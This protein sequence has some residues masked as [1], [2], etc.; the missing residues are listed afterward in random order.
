MASNKKTI[1]GSSTVNDSGTFTT[2]TWVE[3]TAAGVN[4]Y[5]IQSAT[6]RASLTLRGSGD[7]IY[8]DDSASAF[9]IKASGKTI[10]LQSDTQK[11]TIA[12]SSV[13]KTNAV[14]ASLHFLDGVLSVG[15][16]AGGTAL[17]LDNT[18][19][20][21][22]AL[23]DINDSLIREDTVVDNPLGVTT[24]SYTG[25]VNTFTLTEVPPSIAKTFLW[26][27]VNTT[28]LKNLVS[29][30][31]TVAN[32]G[33][34]LVTTTTSN[35]T[36]H[37][38]I[39]GTFFDPAYVELLNN[40]IN[41]TTYKDLV[42]E[43][44]T[45]NPAYISTTGKTK[46]VLE[47]GNTGAGDDV[48]V[49][50]TAYALNGAYINGGGGKNTLEVEMK[51]PFAQP[52][53]LLNIQ[54]VK[55]HNAPNYYDND[56][57]GY[58]NSQRTGSG[59]LNSAGVDG[60][61]DT[62]NLQTPDLVN[63][64][65]S[66]L[67][68]TN[69]AKLENLVVT[70]SGLAG[71][72]GL[73]GSGSVPA[74]DLTILGIKNYP[75][76]TLEGGFSK[77]V[78][79][80]YTTGQKAVL[81]L[82]LVN[83]DFT[84]N[85]ATN[86][87]TA[88]GLLNVAHN[89]GHVRI[90]SQGYS[91]ILDQ[92][93]F[94][95]KFQKLTV[96]GEG[97][98]SVEEDLQFAWGVAT[99]DASQNTGGLLVDV[100]GDIAAKASILGL[101][102]INITGSQANDIISVKGAV[103]GALMKI[104]L[105][106]G[107]NNVLNLDSAVNAGAKSV[108]GST[109]GTLTV[110]VNVKDVDLTR[111]N[112]NDVDFFVLTDAAA[113]GA[114][115]DGVMGT[116]DDVVAGT[117]DGVNSANATILKITQ[118]QF[119]TLGADKFIPSHDG[120]LINLKV[121]ISADTNFADLGD[122]S[123]LDSNV[124]LQ[125]DIAQR[126]TLTM[127]AAQLD[128][129]VAVGGIVLGNG[130]TDSLGKLKITDAG[131]NFDIENN[132]LVA[133]PENPYNLGGTVVDNWGGLKNV[134]VIHTQNGYDRA[135]AEDLVDTLTIDSTA[136]A[137]TVNANA[138]GNASQFNIN[139]EKLIIQGKHDVGFTAPV[140]FG[141]DNFKI[142]ASA[143]KGVT[144]PAVP[145]TPAV[146]AADGVTVITPAVPGTP[147]STTSASLNGLTI[148]DFNRITIGAENTWGNVKGTDGNDRV[149]VTLS[150]N[151]GTGASFATGGLKSTGVE[152]YVV[153][154][155]DGN[156]TFNVCDT[157]QGL[158]TLGLQGNAGKV[159]TFNNVKFNVGFI[160]EGDGKGAYSELPK[161]AGNPNYSNVG[162]LTAKYYTYDENFTANVAISN[163]GK[164]LGLQTDGV[165]A[166]ILHVDG[167]NIDN[168]KIANINIT[169]GNAVIAGINATGAN[170]L[171]HVKLNSAND[172]TVSLNQEA[173]NFTNF[174][175]SA[176]TGTTT[177]VIG[178]TDAGFTPTYA[179]DAFAVVDL[180]AATVTGIEA[181]KIIEGGTLS[182][183]LNQLNTITPAKITV[184]D[185][186]DAG[187][188]V[189]NATLN[190]VGL[191][192]VE[193]K[194]SSF[195]TGV[196]LGTLTVAN[197]TTDSISNNETITLAATTDLTGVTKII[198][199]AGMTLNLTAAQ[200]QQLNGKGLVD[201]NGTINITNLKQTDVDA[202]FDLSGIHNIG[203]GKYGTITLAENVVLK[204]GTLLGENLGTGVIGGAAMRVEGSVN[205]ILPAT[206]VVTATID[207]LDNGK[208]VTNLGFAFGLT[209]NQEI[210]LAN[211][212]Q[213]H[214]RVITGATGTKVTFSFTNIPA[215]T[216]DFF[217]NGAAALPGLN[218]AYYANVSTVSV[219]PAL[220]AGT[221]VEQRLG[222]LNKDTLVLIDQPTTVSA[223][224]PTYRN[225][226]VA[227]GDTVAGSLA[228]QN[229]NYNDPLFVK[230][231]DLA[232]TLKGGSTITGALDIP[233]GLVVS[234]GFKT[235][236]INS[237]GSTVNT[238]GNITAG[239]D[240]VVATENNLLDVV[241]NASSNLVAGDIVFTSVTAS[242]ATAE[243]KFTV[244]TGSTANVTLTKLN[245][246]DA[247]VDTLTVTNNG[248]GTLTVTGASP[249][250]TTGATAE[251]IN[252]KGTG[253]IKFGTV[254]TDATT[255]LVTD[256]DPSVATAAALTINAST[257]SG[258]LDLG[259]V[260]P[261][262][263]FTFTAGTGV[264]KLTLGGDDSLNV[265]ADTATAQLNTGDVWSVDLSTAAAGS[266]LTI[267]NSAVFNAST[268]QV[269]IKLG[270]SG[271]NTVV[272]D[273][274]NTIGNLDKFSIAGKGTLQI[275][276]AVNFT[277]LGTTTTG[278]VTTQ[279]LTLGD[280]DI[281]LAA[282]ASVQMTDA[283][284]A[285]F[286]AAGGTITGA[287][288]TLLVDDMNAGNLTTYRGL[289]AIQID[290]ALAPTPTITMTPEQAAVAT[291]VTNTLGVV[292]AAAWDNPD[293]T[294][295]ANPYLAGDLRDAA[296]T[297]NFTVV[298][299][300]AANVTTLK[301]IDQFVLPNDATALTMN[302]I[303]LT[304]NN[305]DLPNLIT[306][307]GPTGAVATQATANLAQLSSL[308]VNVNVDL[309]TTNL[310][311]VHD[312]SN[313]QFVFTYASPNWTVAG[314]AAAIGNAQ[315]NPTIDALLS[316]ATAIAWN[317]V[318]STATEYVSNVTGNVFDL[319]ANT[320]VVDTF[321]F[322][323]SPEFSSASA[324]TDIVNFNVTAG[325]DTAV[326]KINLDLLTSD[327][328]L[329]DLAAG[330]ATFAAD[331]VYF[332]NG[333]VAAVAEVTNVTFGAF[334]SGQ[335]VTLNGV[336]VTAPASGLTAAT[337]AGI[338]D[339]NA[340]S[341]TPADVLTGAETFA[342]TSGAAAN[343]VTITADATG[344]QADLANIGT[345]AAAVVVGTQGVT[346]VAA[347]AEVTA[348]TFPTLTGGQTSIVNGITITAP[349]GGLPAADVASIYAGEAD[350]IAGTNT[351]GYATGAVAGTAVTFTSSA[352]GAKV[353]LTNT[354]T[355]ATVVVV[356]T[357]GVNAVPA[358]KE[359]FTVTFNTAADA[360]DTITFDGVTYTVAVGG[361]A[362]ATATA[363]AFATAYGVGTT[364]DAVDNLDGTITF[365]A[366][367]AGT[368]TDI[369]TPDFVFVNADPTTT[370]TVTVAV[371]STPGAAAVAAVAEVATVTFSA[372]TSGQTVILNGVT[373]TAP[374]GGLTAAGVASLFANEASGAATFDV[375]TGTNTVAQTGTSTGAVATLTADATGTQADL[376]AAGTGAA[377]GISVTTQGAAAI[378][379]VAEVT[380]VTFSALTSGQ[381]VV[382][383]G[384]TI[385]APSGGLTANEVAS[386]F[387]SETDI[388]SGSMSATYTTGAQAAGVVTFTAVTA[389]VLADLTAAGTGTATPVVTTQ[390]AAAIP[391]AGAA[392]SLA[393]A[394]A[395]LSGKFTT[396]GAA[397]AISYAIVADDNSTAIY[398]IT[399]ASVP[400][401]TIDVA[402][403]VLV[404]TV[405]GVLT[406]SNFIFA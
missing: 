80:H 46:G 294:G 124:K 68:L 105:G 395:L 287:G 191:D 7:D 8:I 265:D 393:G 168:A 150:G 319:S 148:A 307:A 324:G 97:K 185:G 247:D 79:L 201:N 13:S 398:K 139:V 327:I 147:A 195:N 330:G 365:T 239:V 198:I 233:G 331:N 351:A 366:K 302:D 166:R 256:I 187:P 369:T 99:I 49:A 28:A 283:Q 14:A 30:A 378:A 275:K 151:V 248:S 53:Q 152:T 131:L 346:A 213:A 59:L 134:T 192:E 178:N 323:A 381:T 38:A 355:G 135:S 22:T 118:A 387:A 81:D 406:A 78:T 12:L 214:N 4:S 396:A 329:T 18:Q 116:L 64:K 102:E 376:T 335:A 282:G 42:D 115:R 112:I 136:A 44:V 242:S 350:V 20:L 6:T 61:V 286:I 240:G 62:T 266:T 374:A 243:A 146:L 285:A 29:Y 158:I 288:T 91:N 33:G 315:G 264:T 295:T 19:Q 45:F 347:V 23:T 186:N 293:V 25:D 390:G 171:Q 58:N 43:Q 27:S 362:N 56:V 183:S 26:D 394:A 304:I 267:D 193:F 317:E 175:A 10:T 163:Q 188:V 339:S 127:T 252:F 341:A 48:I 203:A 94:G 402:E 322:V 129:Y 77:N 143:L 66:I 296:V 190:L 75:L 157:T 262:D 211:E 72:T 103:P 106:K 165:T 385:T 172:V 219:L 305:T 277:A 284:Y 128:K 363:S 279:D 312:T 174:D 253:A 54:T 114:G 232:L 51:G 300:Q 371:P 156:H 31:N 161:A 334:T 55:V 399:E 342:S 141:V 375:L 207:E 153:T 360:G 370:E 380:N 100:A 237:Q 336:T 32:R 251:T 132:A 250:I 71:N 400:T 401:A 404:G 173:S 93:D 126:A 298:I 388:V 60:A 111:A 130:A 162:T 180:S 2:Q 226:E 101:K 225:V 117:N 259:T 263:D 306:A 299:N 364:W 21:T 123:K 82:K 245:I 104:D 246:A 218:L 229:L 236:T 333:G 274:T 15:N 221:N 337:V 212:V 140:K 181:V 208:A 292:T 138:L 255:G 353:D 384:L 344:A 290:K 40:I 11:I 3:T 383:N 92:V 318:G 96:K 83:V 309:G 67:D 216:V 205:A 270:T 5:V 39:D 230:L 73:P 238:I 320:N 167:I 254:T 196:T 182:L 1:T 314:N 113:Y 405:D 316:K 76:T 303:A 379:A 217:D 368:I 120:T 36:A 74:G 261:S 325:A 176:V 109:E 289:T 372:L 52:K 37:G 297:A 280:L 169:D 310:A 164:V 90:D 206:S 149:N 170:E 210:T 108:I 222:N 338:F 154:G 268:G 260:T 348:V 89:A 326:D 321:K 235:L 345:G 145:G 272:F 85:A 373:V 367:V 24:E 197:R 377:A 209:A 35:D 86:G 301:G 95:A 343:V 361:T 133:A 159:I 258:A 110:N 204:N 119:K 179:D 308:T 271:N 194:V 397:G 63:S 160:M 391:V 382:V 244:A 257:L 231:T 155:L 50:G 328:A 184:I 276:G 144:I 358:V 227:T 215:A 16:K 281:V 241:V 359:V 224:N 403:L 249:A 313:G 88:V 70:E 386:I 65:N 273:G 199:P 107:D 17:F 234:Q 57:F 332:S 354:G 98:L 84:G 357:Q 269:D 177:V 142:D 202:G 340:A 200:F 352:V 349:A 87:G 278:T 228:F 392:D 223:V 389:G 356:G 47:G 9:Q 189:G 220:V 311:G 291:I 125:F 137:I 34:N 122:F 121:V 41:S 69:A